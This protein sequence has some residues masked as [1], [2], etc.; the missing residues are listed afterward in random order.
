MSKY[1]SKGDRPSKKGEL[2]NFTSCTT[3][4]ESPNTHTMRINSVDGIHAHK[5]SGRYAYVSFSRYAYKLS[6]RGRGFKVVSRPAFKGATPRDFDQGLALNSLATTIPPNTAKPVGEFV[7]VQGGSVPK[8]PST[9]WGACDTLRKA[10]KA[11]VEIWRIKL[12]GK[13]VFRPCPKSDE[14]VEKVEGITNKLDVYWSRIVCSGGKIPRAI[15][16]R[17]RL[18]S[19]WKDE[20]LG[21]LLGGK[22]SRP[23]FKVSDEY[24]EWRYGRDGCNPDF[25]EVAE[26][27]WIARMKR[28]SVT[29]G[30]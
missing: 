17:L 22:I 9:W 19:G 28:V 23:S 15:A 27:E 20:F 3:G 8:H 12:T 25:D 16:G 4:I 30:I 13:A 2:D 6:P 21:I 18:K 1:I 11:R 10:V 5:S 24:W 29:V 7:E 14:W 26:I